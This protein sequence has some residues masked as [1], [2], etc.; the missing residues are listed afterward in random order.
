MKAKPGPHCH[1]GNASDPRASRPEG[2]VSDVETDAASVSDRSFDTWLTD[3][4]EPSNPDLL[5]H[6]GSAI[7]PQMTPQP[8]LRAEANMSSKSQV[9]PYR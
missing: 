5:Y 4:Y 8:C 7:Q 6:L 2:Q 3:G 9:R 1:C